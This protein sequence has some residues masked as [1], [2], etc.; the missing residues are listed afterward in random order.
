MWLGFLPYIGTYRK[1]PELIPGTFLRFRIPEK[2]HFQSASNR[3]QGAFVTGSVLAGS[4][5]AGS[6][7]AGSMLAGAGCTG[8]VGVAAGASAGVA[9]GAPAGADCSGAG[10]TA[11]WAGTGAG[12][13]VDGVAMVAGKVR[14]CTVAGS[15]RS[16]R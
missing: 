11:G 16:L 5:L 3:L 9:V 6:E 12:C 2:P 13:I 14:V 1:V 8:A 10:L 4:V 15:S 7:L